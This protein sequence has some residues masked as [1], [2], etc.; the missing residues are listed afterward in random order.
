MNGVCSVVNSSTDENT[1]SKNIAAV[2]Q[3]VQTKAGEE[4]D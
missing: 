3:K 1:A 2:L 4:R